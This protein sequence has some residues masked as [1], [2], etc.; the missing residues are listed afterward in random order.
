MTRTGFYLR[1][2]ASIALD[3]ADFTIG[4]ALFP[5]LWEEGVGTAITLAL[6]GPAGLAYALEFA[7]LTEQLDA[8]IPTA[9]LIGLYVG[10][11]KGFLFP[12]RNSLD[13]RGPG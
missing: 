13:Q 5:V 3:L 10:W 12:A 2:A 11:R 4:R 9:T 1:L 7:D 6:W 8:F